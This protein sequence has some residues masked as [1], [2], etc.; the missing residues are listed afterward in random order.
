MIVKVFKSPTEGA[1]VITNRDKSIRYAVAL[2]ETL[3]SKMNRRDRAY[4]E[5]TQLAGGDVALGKR[6]PNQNW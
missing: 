3:R 5:A 6:L 2:D 1:A 4:F